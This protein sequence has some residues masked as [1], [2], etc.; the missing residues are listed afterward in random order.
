VKRGNI[1]K[2]GRNSWRLK[3]D[4][5]SHPATGSRRTQFVTF[6]G[7]KREAQIKLAELIAAAGSD[8]FVEPHKMTVA[9]LVRARVNQWENAEQVSPRTAQ[10]YRQLLEGQIVPHIGATPIQKLTTVDVETWHTTLRTWGRQRGKGGVSPRTVVHAHRVL[11]HALDDAARHGLVSRNVAK[12]QPP[13]RVEG[14]EMA[15][16]DDGGIDQ[17][18]AELRGDPIYCPAVLALFTGMRL[19]EALA[20]RWSNVDLDGAARISV[21]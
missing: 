9:E 1:T 18:I 20:L 7:T 2:R 6:R 4:L 13:P 16:L 3:F 11:S 5:D 12:L 8:T 21:R 19:G 14:D 10:R 17:L 15:I